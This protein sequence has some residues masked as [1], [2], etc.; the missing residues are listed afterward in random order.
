MVAGASPRVTRN[1]DTPCRGA[2][3]GSRSESAYGQVNSSSKGF[4]AGCNGL[5]M[6]MPKALPVIL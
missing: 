5:A 2:A 1:G 6:S 4:F 3:V